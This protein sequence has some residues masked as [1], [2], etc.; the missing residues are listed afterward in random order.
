[1]F[2]R[3]AI[4]QVW[5]LISAAILVA[6]GV[7]MRVWICKTCQPYCL[8]PRYVRKG[9][10]S[11]LYRWSLRCLS[12]GIWWILGL[13]NHGV[14]NATGCV[15]SRIGRIGKWL[16]KWRWSLSGFVGGM[17]G[18][19]RGCLASIGMII[20]AAAFSCYVIVHGLGTLSCY[21]ADFKSPVNGYVAQLLLKL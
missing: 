7:G 20:A 1:M 10:R 9:A 21:F 19:C 15:G 14:W 18:L 16:I 4:L 8:V 11:M 2:H 17:S 13:V 5:R 12:L 3:S 6:R